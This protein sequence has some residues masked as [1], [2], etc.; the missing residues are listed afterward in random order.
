MNEEM[1]KDQI[2]QLQTDLEIMRKQKEYFEQFYNPCVRIYYGRIAMS[3][4][5]V[6][7][8]IAEIENLLRESNTN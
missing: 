8:G 6:L 7:D 5:A 4:S 2:S 1:L 3:E